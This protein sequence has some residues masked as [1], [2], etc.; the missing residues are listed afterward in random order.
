VAFQR[1]GRTGGYRIYIATA[2]SATPP[3]E[4]RPGGP[5]FLDAPSWS[6][7][8]AWLAAVVGMP[9]GEAHL[10][11]ARI[12]GSSEPVTLNRNVLPFSRPEWSPDGRHILFASN[13]GLAIVDADGGPARTVSEE[14]WIAQTWSA[15]ARTIYGLREAAV[16][17]HFMLAA[18]DVATGVERTI[19]PDLGVIPPA[20]QPIRGL[21][22]YGQAA[23]VTSIAR[24]RSD[25]WMLEGFR[26]PRAGLSRLWEVLSGER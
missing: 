4:F 18:V 16:D 1:L 19:N 17:R 3:V 14:T 20:N 5:S 26:A 15:D 13:D 7:D 22:R 21:T 10:I 2:A 11:K 6:P 9:G 24:A 23:V 12:G 25:I 8:G